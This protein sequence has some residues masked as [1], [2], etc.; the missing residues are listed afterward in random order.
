[1]KK[2]RKEGENDMIP[3]LHILFA[4]GLPCYAIW[5]SQ[6][7]RPLRHPYFFSI[8]SFVFCASG[9]IAELFTVKARLLSGD[10]GGLE[11]TIDA[12]LM[13]CVVFLVITAVLNLVLLG[14][15]YEP[16]GEP[17]TDP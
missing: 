7:H 6:K 16:E 3:L 15:T 9:I 11:D 1:M 10:F 5:R 14:L 4:F 8:G 17:R 12:V 13:I 2:S